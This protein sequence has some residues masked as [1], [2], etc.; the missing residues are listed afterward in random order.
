[1]TTFELILAAEKA[2]SDDDEA[3][4]NLGLAQAAKQRTA[5][6]LVAANQA[7]H[8]DLAANGPACVV[9]ASVTPPRVTMYT[10]ADPDT[11]EATEI[12]VA[13]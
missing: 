7:L 11:Y 12:R 6:A 3:S 8:D 13:A 1:M 10:A 5:A 4:V 2:K 9:D